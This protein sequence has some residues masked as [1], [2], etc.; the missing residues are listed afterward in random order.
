MT[1][2]PLCP[3]C[4]AFWARHTRVNADGETEANTIGRY[5]P[6]SPPKG[7]ALAVVGTTSGAPAWTEE[8]Y[9]EWLTSIGACRSDVAAEVARRQFN[10]PPVTVVRIEAKEPA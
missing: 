5:C 6:C 1:T 2:R 3:D 10:P 4:V 8:Q 9:A 7:P